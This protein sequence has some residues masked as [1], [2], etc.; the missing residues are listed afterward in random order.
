[1]RAGRLDEKVSFYAKV[2]TTNSDFGGT[3]DS[4]PTLT[5]NT[6]GEV[7]YAGGDATISNEEK[8]YSGTIFLKVRYR[9]TI[10][11][12]M[13]VLIDAVWYRITYIEELGRK[14]GLRITLQ[15]INE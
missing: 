12:T 15:K 4:W 10:V 5:F 8:F 7:T 14:E 2:K 1:M 3:T 13:R 6:W 11:E 9:S